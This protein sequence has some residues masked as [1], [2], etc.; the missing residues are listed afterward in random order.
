MKR[1]G[2]YSS[3]GTFLPSRQ[4]LELTFRDCLATLKS[5]LGHGF[6]AILLI[7]LI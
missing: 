2:A 4:V 7:G 5:K 3:P 1:P 6:F